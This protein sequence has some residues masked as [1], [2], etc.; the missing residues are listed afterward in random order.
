[1]NRA[2]SLG[3]IPFFLITLHCENALFSLLVYLPL[4]NTVFGGQRAARRY[5]VTQ[6]TEADMG[7]RQGEGGPVIE[8]GSLRA[9]GEQR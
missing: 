8:R 4:S 1:M 7:E 2:V 5:G 6:G 3:R 9:G